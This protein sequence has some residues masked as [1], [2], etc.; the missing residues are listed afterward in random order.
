MDKKECPL[1]EN[2]VEEKD[3]TYH[4]QIEEVLIDLIKKNHPQWVAYDGACPK[5]VEY[6]RA[7]F[8]HEE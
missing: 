8:D 5:C 3:F 7:I 4:H 1:C 6:Y 2:V